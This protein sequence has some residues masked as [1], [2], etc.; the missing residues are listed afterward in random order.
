MRCEPCRVRGSTRN[1]NS[2]A[3]SRCDRGWGGGRFDCGVFWWGRGKLETCSTFYWLSAFFDQ[4]GPAEEAVGDAGGFV[5]A[6]FV[7]G[8]DLE[9]WAELRRSC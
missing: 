2:L 5:E 7:G 4:A 8:E 6:E 3:M 9:G 1:L